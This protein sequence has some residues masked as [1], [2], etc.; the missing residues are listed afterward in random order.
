M[1]ID[2]TTLSE[3]ELKNLIANYRRLNATAQPLFRKALNELEHRK[4]KGLDFEK[5]LAIIRNAAEQGRFLSYKDLADESGAEW[6]HVHYSIG[7]HLWQLVEYADL[8]GWP[9]LSAIVVNQENV[10]SGQM[11]PGTLKGFVGAARMLG[12]PVIDPEAFLIEQQT[13]VFDWAKDRACKA[14]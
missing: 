14:D 5:S 9:M 3:D 6:T 13:R 4:G 12:Y 7:A 1:G 8:R 10:K 2:V 11:E